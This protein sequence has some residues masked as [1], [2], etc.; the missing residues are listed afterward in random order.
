MITSKN[1]AVSPRYTIS[2]N[3]SFP[4]TGISTT[5]NHIDFNK[6]KEFNYKYKPK[7]K[8]K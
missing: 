1:G 6:L 4:Q 2:L 5:T 7:T 3:T 8:G